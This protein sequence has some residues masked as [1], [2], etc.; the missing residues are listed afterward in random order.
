MIVEAEMSFDE[1]MAW[2]FW[3]GPGRLNSAAL[4]ITWFAM[5][6]FVA[7]TTA[8][9]ISYVEINQG[10]AAIVGGICAAVIVV[11]LKAF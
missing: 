5:G 2:K 10:A 7:S 8:T 11:C 4:V 3:R 6:A 1:P 9:Y